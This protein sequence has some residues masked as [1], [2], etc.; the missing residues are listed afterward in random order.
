MS[1]LLEV[2]NLEVSFFTDLG[3]VKAVK[4]AS[5]QVERGEV[6]GIVGES[7]SGK[8]VA[9]KT[10]LRLGP[11]NIR[12]KAGEI[13]FEEDTDLLKLPMKQ[14][15]EIRGNR[16]SMVFQDSLSALN[17]VY[18]VG[19][20]MVELLRRHEK[21]SKQEARERV[22]T[23]FHDVGIV[24]PERCFH[25]YPH[26]LSGGMRQ[27][28]MIAMAICC[29]PDLM[30]AD[31]PTTALDVTIQAQILHLLRD[32]QRE[33]G[34][35]VILITHDLGVVAQMCSRVAVMC[36]GYVVEE[37]SVGDI[38]HHPCHPYTRALIASMPR[39]GA[40]KLEQFLERSYIDNRDRE[41]C[42]FY[43]RCKYAAEA[44]ENR[45]PMMQTVSGNHKVFCHLGEEA[46][47]EWESD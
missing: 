41:V 44:C 37:G 20:K 27:R 19:K 23:L 12:V 32:I 13:L 33:K 42:P 47:H 31:E 5:F 34:M 40:G 16:I 21:L 15:R 39:A 26:E 30:I 45:L 24:D 11:S 7:G 4:N 28:I 25:S 43:G 35:S 29:D 18:P 2:N 1:H 8:S 10:I 36:G 46:R 22:L 6:Y 17:P 14:L 9:T 3:E 38:F